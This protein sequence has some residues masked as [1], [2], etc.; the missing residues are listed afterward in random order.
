MVCTDNPVCSRI[1]KSNLIGRFLNNSRFTVF[2]RTDQ[3]R[4]RD[5]GFML[6]CNRISLLYRR[7][8][9]QYLT[10]QQR[11][12]H[13]SRYRHRR[14]GCIDRHSQSRFVHTRQYPGHSRPTDR[15]KT[16]SVGRLIKRDQFITGKI[17]PYIKVKITPDQ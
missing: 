5:K 10:R 12:R 13:S 14:F 4:L 11:D 15:S 9:L 16:I 17:I 1:E 3:Q 2:R 7:S 6:L 8:I